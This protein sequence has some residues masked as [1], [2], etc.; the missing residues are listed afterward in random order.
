MKLYGAVVFWI[1]MTNCSLEIFTNHPIVLLRI[2]KNLLHFFK[3]AMQAGYSHLL[4]TGDFNYKEIDWSIML[5]T[6]NTEHDASIFL[7][8]IR[9][10]YLTQSV[11]QPTRF[12]DN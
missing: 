5:S 9:D 10:F 7:E 3:S 4:I 8:V 2:M 12:R 6:E 1:I 11:T